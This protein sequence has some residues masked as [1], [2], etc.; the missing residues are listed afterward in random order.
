M[1]PE[2]ICAEGPLKVGNPN[3]SKLNNNNMVRTIDENALIPNMFF[4]WSNYEP[5]EIYGASKIC[6]AI[7]Q[8]VML[9]AAIVKHR[10]F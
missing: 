6:D 9:G 2:I 7:F 4:F 5:G 10:R 3:I 8:I 1:R